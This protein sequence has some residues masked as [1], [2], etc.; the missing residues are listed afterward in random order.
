[1]LKEIVGFQ[2][3]RTITDQI[4]SIII[5]EICKKKNS[6]MNLTHHHQR[7]LFAILPIVI[8]DHIDPG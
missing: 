5:K 1:M 8:D 4:V 6:P 3:N 2:N 7:I